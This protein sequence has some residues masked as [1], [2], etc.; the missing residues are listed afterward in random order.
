MFYQIARNFS[1]QWEGLIARPFADL[2]ISSNNK[3]EQELSVCDYTCDPDSVFCLGHGVHQMVL[4]ESFI[5][6]P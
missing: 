6:A 5:E 2:Y 1:F 3:E 4:T